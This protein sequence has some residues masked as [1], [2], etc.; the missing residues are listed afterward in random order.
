MNTQTP[1]SVDDLITAIHY[2]DN[3]EKIKIITE[4]LAGSDIDGAVIIALEQ[5]IKNLRAH[6]RVGDED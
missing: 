6:G 3:D 2:L 4:V 5:Y 1:V